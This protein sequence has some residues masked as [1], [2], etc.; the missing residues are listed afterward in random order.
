MDVMMSNNNLTQSTISASKSNELEEIA[1][2]AMKL[3]TGK[4]IHTISASKKDLQKQFEFCLKF[5]EVKYEAD[6]NMG[7]LVVYR[8]K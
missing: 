8:K 4:I 3:A 1:K 2:K 7:F 6:T 5:Y